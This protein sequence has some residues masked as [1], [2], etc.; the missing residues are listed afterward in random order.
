VSEK[1][2]EISEKELLEKIEDHLNGIET[3]M[4]ISFLMG[5]GALVVVVFLSVLGIRII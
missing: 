2:E 1:K 5:L 4:I 3:L